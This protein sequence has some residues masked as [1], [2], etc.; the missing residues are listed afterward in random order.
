M[1]QE[2]VLELV[3]QVMYPV[4]SVKLLAELAHWEKCRKAIIQSDW[5][6]PLGLLTLKKNNHDFNY[7]LSDLL[8]SLAK[9][10]ALQNQLIAKGALETIQIILEEDELELKTCIQTVSALAMLTSNPDIC[11]R[12][13]SS[14]ILSSLKKHT[15]VESDELHV[16]LAKIIAAL[17]F[18][19]ENKKKLVED[20]WLKLL[21]KWAKSENKYTRL[22]TIYSLGSLLK[23]ETI[24][25]KIVRDQGMQ[26]FIQLAS[27]IDVDIHHA[28][29]NILL[30][31]KQENEK[32]RVILEQLHQERILLN[33]DFD[34]VDTS[35]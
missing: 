26:L 31:L 27:I 15:N 4:K 6:F 13:V 7:F 12:I 3:N 9:E 8:E 24:A 23:D 32:H 28:V 35:K 11:N 34:F 5:E 2:G 22:S 16:H 10:E 30:Q 25:V 20:G 19:E 18:N 14:G 29:E 33:D 1:I 17:T 21:C